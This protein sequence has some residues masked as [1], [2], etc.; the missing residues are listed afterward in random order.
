MSYGHVLKT[1]GRREESI[2]AYRKAIAIAPSLGE[3]WWSLANLKTVA[4]DQADIEAME[5]AL[6][7]ARLTE[8]DRFHIHF[9]LGKALEDRGSAEPSFRHYAEGNRMRRQMIGYDPEQVS[10]TVRQSKALFTADFFRTRAGWGHAARDPIFI[11]GMPR[12]GSTLLEQI[13]SSHSAIE[14]TME[15][16]DVPELVKRLNRA[17]AEP[18]SGSYPELLSGL[19]ERQFASLGA[20]Y[21]ERTRIQRKTRKPFYIDKLPNN[22]LHIGFIHL[23]LP[24]ARII[25]IRR[26]PLDCCFS[27]FK[28]HYARGQAFS[29]SLSDVGQYYADYVRL[30]SHFDQVLPGRIH[31][32][33]YERLVEDPEAEVRRLLGVLELPFEEACLRFH[34]NERAVRTASSEQVRQPINR[35]GIAQWQKFEPW[36]GELKEALGPVLASYPEVPNLA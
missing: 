20:E 24:N 35:R 15:L 33:F 30:T 29:Y 12:A 18:N 27:N 1:I 9:A 4:F 32:I 3:A 36:L 23:M 22:W 25:D 26:H 19:D 10:G 31:R 16:P 11:L 28:Q 6:Q 5:R 34:E 13:L 14:G 21:V 17:G 8:E 2:A 7:S